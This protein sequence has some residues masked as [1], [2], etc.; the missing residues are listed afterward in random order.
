ML[1]RIRRLTAVAAVAI[2]MVVV[3]D[4][5]LCAEAGTLS[6]RGLILRVKHPGGNTFISQHRVEPTYHPEAESKRLINPIF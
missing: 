3:V 6:R 1:Q 2:I 4:V 5:G